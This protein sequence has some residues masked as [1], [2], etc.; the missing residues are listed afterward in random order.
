[1]KYLFSNPGLQTLE[2]ICQQTCLFAFDFDGTLCR[3]SGKPDGAQVSASTQM[4][5]QEILPL[6]LTAIISGR[7]LL[8]LKQLLPFQP[9]FLVGN[10]GLESPH[11]SPTLIQSAKNTTHSWLKA[12]HTDFELYRGVFLEDKSFSLSFHYRTAFKKALAR[13]N[14][15]E[16]AKQLEPTP[17]II[18]GKYV[19]NLVPP[20]SPHKGVALQSLLE[21]HQID[22]AVYVGDDLTDEDV[23]SLNDP[24][25]LSVRIGKTPK[26]SAQY[27]LNR[28]SEINRLL[29]HILFFL[30][31][32]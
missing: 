25:V 8:D 17:R 4:L 3:L 11:S 13:R 22:T 28:Q 31:K 15:L 27:Y 29:S 14:I 6:G 18:L 30:K 23:F 2:A 19:V 26:S 21:H 7:G 1:M 12:I 24:R 10:H 9:N 5:I 20:N 32:H 16:I